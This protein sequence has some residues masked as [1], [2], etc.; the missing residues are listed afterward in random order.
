[1]VAIDTGPLLRR[2]H[3]RRGGEPDICPHVDQHWF[4]PAREAVHLHY[5]KYLEPDRGTVGNRAEGNPMC[6]LYERSVCHRV[7]VS[8]TFSF[9]FDCPEDDEWLRSMASPA[10]LGEILACLKVVR[11]QFDETSPIQS[12][13]FVTPGEE[14]VVLVDALDHER[15][16][17]FRMLWN[18]HRVYSD[19]LIEDLFTEFKSDDSEII[20]I[21]EDGVD[22]AVREAAMER[23]VGWLLKR[24]RE[25]MDSLGPMSE[26]V[27]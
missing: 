17:K 10:D 9:I 4:D 12:R 16:S 8:L 6:I 7:P 13:L 1:M 11:I 23:Q 20:P 19:P 25:Q 24:W 22:A 26:D 2:E 14:R 5:T 27:W 3:R 21:E 15:I 18:A